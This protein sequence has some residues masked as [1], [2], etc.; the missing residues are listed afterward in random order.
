MKSTASGYVGQPFSALEAACG[1]GYVWA[2]NIGCLDDG[3]DLATATYSDFTVQCSR[4]P[5]GDWIVQY[6]F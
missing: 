6:V 3:G 5:G 4:T 2:E 1:G